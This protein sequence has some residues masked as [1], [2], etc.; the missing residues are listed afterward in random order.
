MDLKN[1]LYLTICNSKHEDVTDFLK[2]VRSSCSDTSVV[3][4]PFGTAGN[5]SLQAHKEV[6]AAA[7]PFLAEILGIS[8]D[9][10]IFITFSDYTLV[11]IKV[12]DQHIH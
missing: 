3:L 2:V 9:C 8:C 5:N 1:E 4:K 6:L 7:S 10:D 11:N 12:F